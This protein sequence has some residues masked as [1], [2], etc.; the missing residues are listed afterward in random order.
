MI[1][2]ITKKKIKRQA[3]LGEYIRKACNWKGFVYTIM[4]TP[5]YMNK[6]VPKQQNFNSLNSETT[7]MPI[8][9]KKKSKR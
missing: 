4:C 3:T 9:S 6:N 8:N 1:R 7:Q 2:K 5:E